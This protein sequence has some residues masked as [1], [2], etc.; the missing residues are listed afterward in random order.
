QG[1][2][3][4]RSEVV[5]FDNPTF[6]VGRNGAGK[7]NLLDALAFLS[8][9]VT[10]P[11]TDAFSWRGGGRVVCYGSSAPSDETEERT[12]GLGIVLGG[13]GEITGARYAIRLAVRGARRPSYAVQKEQCVVRGRDGRL[14]YFERLEDGTF[15]SN[16]AGFEP[17]LANDSLALR[18]IGGDA[19]FAP[20]FD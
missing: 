1:F 8:D 18:L 16:L 17:R 6:L 3:S 9:A 11:L 12:L 10:S 15:R 4:F 13:F 5:D 2:R 20:V 7:S 14:D 19:R